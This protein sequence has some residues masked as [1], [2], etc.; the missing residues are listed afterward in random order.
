MENNTNNIR[1]PNVWSDYSFM[2]DFLFSST[3]NNMKEDSQKSLNDF[4]QGIITFKV[5][6]VKQV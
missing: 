1:T 4:I 5:K 3:D 6:K 2:T